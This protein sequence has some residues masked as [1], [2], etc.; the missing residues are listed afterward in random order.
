MAGS[1]RRENYGLG[2]P[3]Q[4]SK[5]YLPK[6]QSK[7]DWKSSSSIRGPA[8][9][10]QST[11]FKSHEHG[12]TLWNGKEIKEKKG[13]KVKG[14]VQWPNNSNEI[15]S[16]PMMSPGPLFWLFMAM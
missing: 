7:K 12:K 8:I 11:M 3:G 14:T 13:R 16:L 5:M 1:I 10:V 15:L 6:N 4:K 9:Y 2:W